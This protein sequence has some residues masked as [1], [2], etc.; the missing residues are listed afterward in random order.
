MES[1]LKVKNPNCRR[2]PREKLFLG[3]GHKGVMKV[4][5]PAGEDIEHN[6]IEKYHVQRIVLESKVQGTMV[7]ASG[8]V[9][10]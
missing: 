7:A 9:M 5:C 3:W 8:G 10:N 4:R 6:A 1:K 2:S